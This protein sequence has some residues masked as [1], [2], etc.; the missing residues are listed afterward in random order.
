M[1][2]VVVPICVGA[3]PKVLYVV[4]PICVGAYL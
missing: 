3:Y 1:L 4:V 2:Y